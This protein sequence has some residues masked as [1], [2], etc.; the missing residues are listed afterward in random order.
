M[1]TYHEIQ[2]PQRRRLL[3]RLDTVSFEVIY[4]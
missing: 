3:V 2:T 4:R 1:I